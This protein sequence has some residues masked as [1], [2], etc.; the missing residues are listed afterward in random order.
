MKFLWNHWFWIT[1]GLSGEVLCESRPYKVQELPANAKNVDDGG[2]SLSAGARGGKVLIIPTNQ[3]VNPSFLQLNRSFD[4]SGR[5]KTSVSVSKSV[6]KV[7]VKVGKISEEPQVESL[8]RF[9]QIYVDRINYGK[10]IPQ[11]RRIDPQYV[12]YNLVYREPPLQVMGKP[13]KPAGFLPLVVV[14]PTKPPGLLHT[15]INKLKSLAKATTSK[16]RL[17][18]LLAGDSPFNSYDTDTAAAPTTA[19]STETAQPLPPAPTT[20]EPAAEKDVIPSSSSKNSNSLESNFLGPVRK[21][22]PGASN[23]YVRVDD[24][25][26][27]AGDQLPSAD[28]S[29]QPA[30]TTQSS[31]DERLNIIEDTLQRDDDDAAKLDTEPQISL[32]QVEKESLPRSLKAR[33]RSLPIHVI[34][35]LEIVRKPVMDR[36]DQALVRIKEVKSQDWERGWKEQSHE[37]WMQGNQSEEEWMEGV[38]SVAA[39]GHQPTDEWREIEESIETDF[40]G[41]GELEIENSVKLISREEQSGHV[42]ANQ[43]DFSQDFNVQ[44]P[45]KLGADDILIEAEKVDPANISAIIGVVVGIIIFVII[46]IVLV[47]LGLQRGEMKKTGPAE[48]VISQSSYMTYST[49]VSEHSVNYGPNWDKDMVE[50]LCSL[51]N[52]SFL[53]SL[54]A[55]ATTDYWGESKY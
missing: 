27:T 10:R 3:S 37:E 42:T 47:L 39:D 50:D 32:V 14:K 8:S 21:N 28:P 33:G 53:N 22:S 51:D 46:S 54:E 11:P 38:Q 9:P 4:Q 19:E 36:F 35:D 7:S 15:I 23:V 17:S 30:S 25:K 40:G 13:S 48:D 44:Q 20:A 49:T 55:V 24:L 29:L 5:S 6:S 16:I 43:G 12:G 52:D 41:N 26:V 18:S 1:L 31:L 45:Q 34:Q 2:V